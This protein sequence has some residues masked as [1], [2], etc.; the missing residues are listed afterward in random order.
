[1]PS[2]FS[3]SRAVFKIIKSAVR[4]S[5]SRTTGLSLSE[6][7]CSSAPS[8]LRCSWNVIKSYNLR[9]EIL[10]AAIVLELLTLY[11]VPHFLIRFRIYTSFPIFSFLFSYYFTWFS[12]FPFL[13]FFF[14]A[15][16]FVV[17][18][19]FLCF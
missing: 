15:F 16:L 2:P 19:S 7:P 9:I 1:M 18:F 6:G 8:A 5:S 3:A 11:A 17:P 13:F 12:P 10:E 14:R 4:S